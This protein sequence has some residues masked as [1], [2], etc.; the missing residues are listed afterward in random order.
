MRYANEKPLELSKAGVVFCHL[1][2]ET[3]LSNPSQSI[4]ICLSLSIFYVAMY[5]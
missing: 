2:C 4:E 3:M 1:K 5:R